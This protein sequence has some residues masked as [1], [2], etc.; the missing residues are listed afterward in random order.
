M[1]GDDMQLRV[2][3]LRDLR[4]VARYFEKCFGTEAVSHIEKRYMLLH[5]ESSQNKYH[6][7]MFDKQLIDFIIQLSTITR[8][9]G[10]GLLIGWLRGENFVPS[11]QLFNYIHSTG[12]RMGCAAIAKTQG[13][14]AF[15]YGNDLLLASLDRIIEPAERGWYVAV[16]DPEDM[17]AVGIGRLLISPH[18]IPELIREG[19]MLIPVVKN[20]FDLGLT[21]RQE[22]FFA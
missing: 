4:S 7:Y 8:V 9:R 13:V 19:R 17:L 1:I 10:A 6:V 18:Q 11:T 20:V 12:F 14:K 3:T 2:S 21:V 5:V 15:L 22:E 16:L